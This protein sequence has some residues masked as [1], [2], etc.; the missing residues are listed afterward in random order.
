MQLLAPVVELARRHAAAGNGRAAEIA[1][2]LGEY[3]RTA[4]AGMV[5][6]GF[7][8]PNHR[9]VVCSA[10]AQALTLFPDLPA[11]DYLDS[12]LAEGIDINADGEYTER[13]TGIYNAVCNRSLRFMADGLDRPDLLDHVRRNLDLMAHLFHHDGTVVTSISNRQDRGQRVVPLSIADSFYDL[14]R[15]DGMGC[16]RPARTNWS[17]PGPT[18]ST[19]SG[20]STPSW[21]TPVTAMTPSR[22]SPCRTITAKSSPRRASGASAAAPSRPPPRRTTPSPSPS[23]T[24]RWR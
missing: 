4:A 10:L 22:A 6:R 1:D 19:G 17:P 5:G 12:I 11:R 7:H 15:R 3:V 16:G 8:T 2:T 21:P 13:S 24:A 9:W 14:A 20:S 18:S 23:A